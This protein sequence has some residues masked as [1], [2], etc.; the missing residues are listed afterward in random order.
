MIEVAAVIGGILA[1]FGLAYYFLFA[2]AVPTPVKA[3]S[4]KDVKSAKM[5]TSDLKEFTTAG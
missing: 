4:P 1:L 5:S 2:E 3:P